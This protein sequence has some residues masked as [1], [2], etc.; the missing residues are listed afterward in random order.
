[1]WRP[2]PHGGRN[3]RRSGRRPKRSSGRSTPTT[4]A[5]IPMRSTGR[6]MLLPREGAVAPPTLLS[7]ASMTLSIPIQHDVDVKGRLERRFAASV[8]VAKSII[9]RQLDRGRV[10]L[11]EKKIRKIEKE[12]SPHACAAAVNRPRRAP[13]RHG[14][15][16]RRAANLIRGALL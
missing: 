15:E 9:L 6:L 11:P 14:K 7:Q 2:P 10:Q 12:R 3:P 5:F 8:F 13:F 4:R 16:T 1:M